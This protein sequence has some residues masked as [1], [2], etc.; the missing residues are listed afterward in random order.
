[1]HEAR[2]GT[3]TL[4]YSGDC[5][6]RDSES[7]TVTRLDAEE[8]VF[9]GFHLRRD[10]SDV[11][12]GEAHFIA[13]MPADARDVLYT[14]AYALQR[15]ADGA[16]VGSETITEGGGAALACLVELGFAGT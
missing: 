4:D 9:D 14:I 6:G 1:M 12:T 5:A 13:P 11:F 7:I 2:L 8:M 15:R 3:W 16:F 10:A